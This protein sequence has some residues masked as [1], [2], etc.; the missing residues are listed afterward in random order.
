M[1]LYRVVRDTPVSGRRPPKARQ[2]HLAVGAPHTWPR[3]GNFAPPER[4]LTGHAPATPRKPLLKAG[5]TGAT[6]M[7]QVELS[8]G[9]VLRATCSDI[10]DTLPHDIPRAVVGP[11]HGHDAV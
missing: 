9:F 2:R 11:G 7:Q 4:H 8:V 10:R 1:K 6:T 3:H 5:P